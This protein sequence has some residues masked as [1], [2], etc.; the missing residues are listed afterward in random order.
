M[1]HNNAYNAVI[2][3]KRIWNRK[4]SAYLLVFKEYL[5]KNFVLPNFVILVKSL[6]P[7][8]IY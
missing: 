2:I 6:K 4:W 3:V 7:V 5:Q 1:K 8:K